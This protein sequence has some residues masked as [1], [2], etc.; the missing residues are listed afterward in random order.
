MIGSRGARLAVPALLAGLL[1]VGCGTGTP[2]TAAAVGSERLTVA[3]V[4]ERT[5]AFFEAYP[6]A[7]SSGVTAG[8]VTA[9]TV[10]NFIRATIVDT[11]AADIGL[12]PTPTELD[13]FVAELGGIE[14]VTRRTSAQGV[15][16]DPELVA[17][18]IRSAYLQ[19]AIGEQ[20]AGPDAA[21]DDIRIASRDATDAIA[22]ELDIEVNPRFGTWE[23]GFVDASNGS[24]SITEAELLAPD[25]GGLP[26]GVPVPAPGG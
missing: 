9:I 14:E 25:G 2:G 23:G 8:Q 26:P 16:P 22:A 1:L 12:E 20:I 15:P 19:F 5:A 4:Q 10:E 11:T 24:L 13:D 18:E 21:D 3:E 17:A 6:E 7:R